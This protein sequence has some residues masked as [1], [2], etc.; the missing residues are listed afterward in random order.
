MRMAS[1]LKNNIL[2]ILIFL[3]GYLA[4]PA[5]SFKKERDFIILDNN[6]KVDSRFVFARV[7]GQI[8]GFEKKLN[9][10]GFAI[11]KEYSLVKG[12]YLIDTNPGNDK[13]HGRDAG[14]Y[15]LSRIKELKNS[16][17]FSY[18]EPNYYKDLLLE[19][20]DNAYVEGDL[21]GLLNTGK[22]N[23]TIGADI[24][25]NA[26]WD[27]TT[28]NKQII[29]SVI[30]SGVRVTHQDL[31]Q[32]MW[33]N[34]DEIAGNGIDDDND[35][36]VDN[37]YGIDPYWGD[38][39]PEDDIGHGT[40]VAGTIGAA[41]NDGNPHVG[42]AWDVQLLACKV[43]SYFLSV[44]A[45][46]DSIEF[47]VEEGAAVANCSFGGMYFSQAE[48][49]A[50]AEGGNNGIMFA[51]A[52]GNYSMNNDVTPFYP[53]SFD[54]EC[55]VSVAATNNK[56]L[57]SSFT[58]TGEESVDL[59]APGVDIY[60]SVS[61]SDN[62]YDY[63]DGTSMASPHVAGV[64]ALMRGLQPS[65]SNLQIR[66]KL[67]SAVD[68]QDTYEG[69]VATSGRLNAFKSVQGMAAEP[70]PDGIME[71]AIYPPSGSLLLANSS[72]NFLA[73]VIDGVGVNNATVI[74]IVEIG[75][76]RNELYF[77]NDGDTPDEIE[78][79]NIYSNN[80]LLPKEGG[81]MKL[82]L[83]VEAPDKVPFYRVA[84]YDVVPIPGNDNFVNA[85]KISSFSESVEGYN[86]FASLEPG[87]PIHSDSIM[88]SASLWWDWTAPADG[89]YYADVQG[90]EI[91]AIM[92]VYVGESIETLSKID[93][94]RDTDQGEVDHL[95]WRGK[96]GR[97]YRICVAGYGQGDRGYVRLRV[98]V[99]GQP[100]I[101]P[102]YIK[103]NYPINGITLATNR[104]ELAGIAMDPQ[105]NSSG[106]KEVIISADGK[107]GITVTG[108]ERWKFK[109]NLNRG[110]NKYD[111]Y[112]VDYSG[113]ISKPATVVID[114][115]PPDVPNDHFIDAIEANTE[116]LIGDGKKR[117][118][119][120]SQKL[121]ST[122]LADIK[123]NNKQIVRDDVSISEINSRILVFKTAPNKGDLIK[124]SFPNWIS[125]AQDTQKATREN[126]EPMHGQN[127]GGGSIWYK[128]EAPSDGILSVETVEGTFDTL[129]AVYLGNNVSNLK[130]LS[131][132][133][134][135][136]LLEKGDNNP[137]YSRVAQ[138]LE[139]GMTVYIAVDGFGGE[140]GEVRV[141]TEFL[142]SPIHR[143]TVVANSGGTL[144]S[145]VS[146]PLK[147]LVGNYTLYAE[148]QIAQ[149]EVKP[150]NGYVF[151]GWK[152]SIN[153]MD[154][155]I[156]LHITKDMY[157]EANFSKSIV[158]ENFESGGF[159]KNG[160]KTFGDNNW[161]VQ[162]DESI[163]GAFSAKAGK[164]S[165]GEY[166][167]LILNGDFSNGNGSFDFKISSEKSWDKLIFLVDGQPLDEWSG[168]TDWENYVFELKDGKYTLEWRYQKDFASSAGQDTAWIDNINLPLKH[169][170]IIS[171]EPNG[172]YAR[173]R[174]W[175]RAGHRYK[176]EVSSDLINWENWDSVLIDSDSVKL[177]ERPI[178]LNGED[179]RFFRATA[180]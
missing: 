125:L 131:E 69:L 42:V 157:V 22:N 25:A 173:L 78:G 49:D 163:G 28:G 96:K 77:G 41:A 34:L 7:I 75:N 162:S 11:E 50:F 83:I 20:N 1:T 90:S 48:F 117:Q 146:Q 79:D 138:A 86:T 46:I 85:Y 99:N 21:W 70:V 8:T 30:D 126:G 73:T 175:G 103:I 76:Y 35:G 58:H 152:G 106:L 38:G 36:Y 27:I 164:I 57:L 101:T 169:N 180:P 87:E 9:N 19:P 31:S 6:A 71:V 166:S 72:T 66:E 2:L 140:R 94:N 64:L 174:L 107:P 154:N 115:R 26:A 124:V 139:E 68:V 59:G 16:G 148:K 63:Y 13:L 102:P 122:L 14:N 133:D 167:S 37:I 145:P 132:N 62:S 24:D 23:G 165:D 160:W 143:L 110:V 65:W 135:N 74:G 93:D 120:F 177:L 88:Q 142:A 111:I 97:T 150:I 17:Y 134:D 3:T 12:L 104:V 15:L 60:S 168:V 82:T 155:P 54:L 176:I 95:T 113:N 128:Y 179:A 172:N 114:H 61:D 171:I 18:V 89:N 92:A 10:A 109:V 67:F 53:C 121:N 47:S 136:E 123:V 39:D 119:T 4:Y 98:E 108:S 116:I 105:P 147:G 5:Q 44:D 56:D 84:K 81:K 161:I 144:L 156:D 178:D 52:A 159:T 170:A 29:V 91:D 45:I 118:F 149:L 129:L 33:I 43:G 80:I 40:H 51:C 32:Q 112:G 137:G 130:L 127:E 55:I 151:D 100:D 153:S 158:T 141:K